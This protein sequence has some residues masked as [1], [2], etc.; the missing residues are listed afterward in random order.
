MN[1]MNIACTHTKNKQPK[2]KGSAN[3]Q[4]TSLS[5]RQACNA[6][7]FQVSD[8]PT[9]SVLHVLLTLAQPEEH[10][11]KHDAEKNVLSE[12]FKQFEAEQTRA[13]NTRHAE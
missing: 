11:S 12:L 8:G 6:L 9:L 3:R 4:K 10:Q 2:A 13:I 7:Q 5:Q 1:D